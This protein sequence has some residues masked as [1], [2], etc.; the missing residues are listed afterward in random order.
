MDPEGEDAEEQI[1]VPTIYRKQIVE[2][3]IS[4]GLSYLEGIFNQYDF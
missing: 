1:N 4:L 2:P 3:E